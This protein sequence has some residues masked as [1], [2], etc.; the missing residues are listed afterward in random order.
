MIKPRSVSGARLRPASLGV[1]LLCACAGFVGACGSSTESKQDY[2]ARANAICENAVR[3][4]RAVSAASAGGGVTL[5]ALG[6]YLGVV[7]PIV[8]SEV[9]QLRAL[10]Q[11]PADR[12]VLA[13]Y[14]AALQAAAAGYRRLGS[15]ARSGDRS[16]VTSATASLQASPSA[17]LAARYGLTTCAGST[18]TVAPS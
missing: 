2:V 12:K 7:T 17:A 16:A 18:G 4:E 8:D 13:Q 1:L 11:P 6:H 15:A 9:K 14:L 5:A 3:A 10:P